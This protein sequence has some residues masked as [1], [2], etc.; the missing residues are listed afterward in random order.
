MRRNER[1]ISTMSIIV[2]IVI[3]LVLLWLVSITKSNQNVIASSTIEVCD[4]KETHLVY[5]QVDLILESIEYGD[6]LWA[7]Y[8]RLLDTYPDLEKV[9]FENWRQ[10]CER[11]NDHGFQAG[12][13]YT[14]YYLEKEYIEGP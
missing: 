10:Q 12:R 2:G 7:T 13:P 1:E 5:N 8:Y 9:S 4:V 3:L 11:M 14:V 6:T